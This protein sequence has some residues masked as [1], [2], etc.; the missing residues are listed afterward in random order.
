MINRRSILGFL[1]GSIIGAALFFPITIPLWWTIL[2]YVG[3]IPG[4]SPRLI[5]QGTIL[6]VGLPLFGAFI[7]GFSGAYLSMKRISLFLFDDKFFTF[8]FWFMFILVVVGVE[9]GYLLSPVVFIGLGNTST[10]FDMW[11][12]P[13]CTGTITLIFVLFIAVLAISLRSILGFIS[14]AIRKL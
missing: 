11:T 13:I 1:V 8:L 14:S 7:G 10:L 3:P 6:F 4:S 12:F 5:E 2:D 9:I